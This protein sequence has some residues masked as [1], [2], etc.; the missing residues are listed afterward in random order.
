[1]CIVEML[2]LYEEPN[3]YEEICNKLNK[4]MRII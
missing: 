1:M 2:K 3:G 4:D